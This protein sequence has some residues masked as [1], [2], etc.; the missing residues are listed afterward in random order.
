[1][2]SCFFDYMLD[3]KYSDIIGAK[4]FEPDEFE[5]EILDTVRNAGYKL[6]YKLES[7]LK[8][9]HALYD[10]LILHPRFD[11]FGPSVESWKKLIIDKIDKPILIITGGPAK[12][13]IYRREIGERK[14]LEYADFMLPKFII[15]F[16]KKYDKK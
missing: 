16:L 4:H 14:N 12:T 10:C 2:K 15:E 6:D 9:D 13:G 11:L 3:P 5:K 7:S 8:T 1:M